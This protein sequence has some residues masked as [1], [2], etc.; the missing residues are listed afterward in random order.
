MTEL[1]R[2]ETTLICPVEDCGWEHVETS[3]LVPEGALAEV[4]GQ[5]VMALQARN[6]HAEKC[7]RILQ[8]HHAGHSVADYLRTITRL[9]QALNR[10]GWVAI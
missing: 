6:Q 9:R 4:F 1:P 2:V 3:P 7:E 5:G 8:Q 10:S